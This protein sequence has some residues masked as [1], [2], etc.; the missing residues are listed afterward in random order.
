MIIIAFLISVVS[1]L[2]FASFRSD[3]MVSL[4]ILLLMSESNVDLPA[5]T[6]PI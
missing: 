4:I 5:M 6:F 3:V 1:I 2:V